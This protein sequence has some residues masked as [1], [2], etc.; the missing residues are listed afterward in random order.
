MQIS[1]LIL[2][3]SADI[4]L[5]NSSMFGIAAFLS[6]HASFNFLGSSAIFTDLSFFMVM[7][8]GQMK[9]FSVVLSAYLGV[10]FRLA[11]PVHA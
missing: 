5:I 11:F 4:L 2:V 1:P 6:T 3:I 9:L 8:A 10:F 7:T